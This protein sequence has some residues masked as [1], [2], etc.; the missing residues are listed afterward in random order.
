M[1]KV[2]KQTKI[3]VAEW[4]GRHLVYLPFYVAQHLGFFAQ[5]GL[6]IAMYQAGNDDQTFQEVAQGRADFGIGDPTFVAAQRHDPADV[7]IIAALVSRVCNWGFTPHPEIKTIKS[8]HDLVTLRV[9]CFPR[10]STTF[11]LLHALKS[12]YPRLLK[13]LSIVEAAIGAQADLLLRGEADIVVDIEPMVSVAEHQSYRVIWNLG[14]FYEEMLFT[15][16]MAS[17]T[18]LEQKQDCAAGLVRAVQ[19]SLAVCHGDRAR[20][21]ATADAL[22]P[23]LPPEV[24]RAS[25]ERMTTAKAWPEQLTVSPQAWRAALR[26]RQEVHDLTHLSNP[27]SFIAAGFAH[28]ALAH[29]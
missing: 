24:V 18:I 3:R 1:P 25:V 9:G 22:F 4:G 28:Q 5:E 15:G 10:P 16:I 14:D 17:R 12:R 19:R 21:V 29:L 23:A 8:P 6:D 2:K 7:K 20:A 11:T 27:E 26:L 13:S